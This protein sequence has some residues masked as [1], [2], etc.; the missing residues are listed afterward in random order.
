M[1]SLPPR[2]PPEAEFPN[3]TRSLPV[4]RTQP[5]P[6]ERLEVFDRTLPSVTPGTSDG[7]ASGY[8]VVVRERVKLKPSESVLVKG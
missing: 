2:H 1:F 6:S 3:K 7:E 5:S 4:S 8:S